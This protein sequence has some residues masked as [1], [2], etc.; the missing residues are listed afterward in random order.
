MN[1]F[2]DQHVKLGRFLDPLCTEDLGP[3]LF[4]L[5]R[6]LRYESPLLG[7]II[8][9][10]AGLQTDLDSVPRWL[11]LVYA[12]LHGKAR[13]A[14]A[15][16]DFCY[17][18]HRVGY[19]DLTRAMADAVIDEAAQAT[20]PGI[21]PLWALDRWMLWAGVRVGGRRAWESG[22]RR[23]VIWDRRSLRRA[24]TRLSHYP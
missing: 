1:L 12:V 4:M 22:P 9:A 7:D 2:M 8:T 10:P 13:A 19:R 5:T 3:D 17:Q 15:I 18:T 21:V 24:E 11:P 23:L 16:H 6:P 20:G 14:G